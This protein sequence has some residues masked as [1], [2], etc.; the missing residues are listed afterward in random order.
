MVLSPATDHRLRAREG[1]RAG[2]SEGL[3]QTST[4]VTSSAG[5]CLDALPDVIAI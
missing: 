4:S 2:V 3:S 5:V 1:A